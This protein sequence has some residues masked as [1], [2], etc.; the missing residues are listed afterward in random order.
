MD[1]PNYHTHFGTSN[2][3]DWLV[4][5]IGGN[6]PHFAC[7]FDVELFTLNSVSQIE[8]TVSSQLLTSYY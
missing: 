3:A 8:T 2:I 5:P 6:P 1:A 4:K 7:T